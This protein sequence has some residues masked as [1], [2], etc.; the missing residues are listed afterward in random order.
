MSRMT[1]TGLPVSDATQEPPSQGGWLLF[2]A[3]MILWAGIWNLFQGFTGFFRSSLLSNHTVGGPLWIWAVLWILFGILQLAASG[4]IMTH[5]SW[6][7]WFG[8][9]TVGLSA[10][11]N[12][13]TVGT[14]PWWSIV[15]IPI[16]I[17]V[18]FSLAVKWGR[19]ARQAI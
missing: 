11:V 1:S 5:R 9:V 17:L 18:L 7:R 8:I 15:L 13:L 4:A 14:N 19:P 16:D 12:L 3:L 2:S 10:F 6:G